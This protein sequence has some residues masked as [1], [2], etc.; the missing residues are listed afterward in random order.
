M[1]GEQVKLDRQLLAAWQDHPGHIG[2][3]RSVV[4]EW[5]RQVS[6]TPRE[7]TP[8]GPW[9]ASRLSAILGELLQFE[10]DIAQV[11][12]WHEEAAVAQLEE[13]FRME[14]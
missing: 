8:T 9:L 12:R 6:S 5:F 4:E 1:S 11:V 7:A 13:Q 10:C 2:E 14:P 3:T